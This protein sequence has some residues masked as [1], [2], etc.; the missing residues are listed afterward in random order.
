MNTVNI[1]G[2]GIMGMLTAHELSQQ[3]YRVSLFD[4]GLAGNESTWAGGGIISPLFPWRYDDAISQL[5]GVSQAL[6]PELL[7]EL[8]AFADIDPEYLHSGLL[9]LDCDDKETAI[10]WSQKFDAPL[11][12]LEKQQLNEQFESLNPVFSH[13]FWMPQIHQI[14]NPRFAQLVKQSLINRGVTFYEH[15]T[16]TALDIRNNCIH[17]IQDTRKQHYPADT[18]IITTGAWTGDFIN[19]VYQDETFELKIQPVHG[20]MLLLKCDKPVFKEIILHDGRYIIPRKDGHVLVGSTTEM[21]GFKK[22]TTPA[23]KQDLL[24]YATHI[25]PALQSARIAKHWSGLRPGS[26]KGIPTIGKHTHI[27]NLFIN[28]GHYRNGLVTAPASAKLIQ[29]II[30]HKKP[31][32][33]TRLFQMK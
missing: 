20:Q 27:D 22:Q 23:V 4:K 24:E 19:Q 33:D 1:I 15:T 10:T 26:I 12:S 31:I 25:V 11:K 7:D 8:R 21:I 14:R 6:Y 18:T 30:D 16:I 28:A 32:L 13:G 5:A 29:Q 2:S 3:G 17:A 9:M